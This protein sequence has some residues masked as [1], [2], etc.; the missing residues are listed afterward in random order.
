MGGITGWRG[1][2]GKRGSVECHD[3]GFT[4]S[5]SMSL[6][7]VLRRRSR[8]PQSQNRPRGTEM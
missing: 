3:A 5:V 1:E 4:V 8:G 6:L 2:E 7:P